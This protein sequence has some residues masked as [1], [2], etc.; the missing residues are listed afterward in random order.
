MG[1]LR[2]FIDKSIAM[3]LIAA[4]LAVS[5]TMP[6]SGPGRISEAALVS[7]AGRAIDIYLD[8]VRSIMEDELDFRGSF[9]GL[10]GEDIATR[11][12]EEEN[13]R[14]YLEFV[15]EMSS[16]DSAEAVISSAEGLVPEDELDS[17]RTEVSEAETRL[18][19]KAE[20]LARLMTPSEEAEFYKDLKKL[21]VKSAVLLTA[22]AVYAFIPSAV[23]W[24]KVTAAA[25]VAIAAG[26]MATSI[27]AVVEYYQLDRDPGEAFEEWLTDVTTEPFVYW[28]IASAMLN[29]SKAMGRGPVLS[30]VILVVFTI[31]GV[32]NDVKP[33]LSHFGNASE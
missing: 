15:L 13:G 5:C 2:I 23:I 26:V 3:L 31:L 21:V 22:A 14:E 25:A 8:D 24:G 33:M 30:S 32:V 10:S 6:V 1:K 7:A 17:I 28:G 27:M 16:Y 9:D 11:A 18:I 19:G 29:L 4:T 20:K 12:I